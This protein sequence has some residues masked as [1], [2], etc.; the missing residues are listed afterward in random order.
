MT[1]HMDERPQDPAEG[2]VRPLL[3]VDTGPS[4]TE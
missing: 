3:P 2:S 1:V 4:E